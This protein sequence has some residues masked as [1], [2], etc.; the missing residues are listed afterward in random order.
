V[1]HWNWTFEK[2][3]TWFQ[4]A[5]PIASDLRGLGQKGKWVGVDGVEILK[6]LAIM[7]VT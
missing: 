4:S 2:V 7:I 6:F 5:E 1:W 3:P